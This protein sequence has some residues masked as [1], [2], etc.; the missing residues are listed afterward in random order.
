MLYDFS[1]DNA[2]KIIEEIQN[3]AG[4][5]GKWALEARKQYINLRLRQDLE[6]RKLYQRTIKNIAKQLKS[7]PNNTHLKELETFIQNEIDKLTGDFTSKMQSYIK[8]AVDAGSGYSEA[9]IIDLVK[10]A[11][12]ENAIRVSS[13]KNIYSRVNTQAVEAI[14][15]RTKK[16]LK[17]SDRIWQTGENARNTIRD[18]IQESVVTGQDAVK[19]ARMLE[20]YVQGG[21]KTL[22]AEYPNMMKRMKGRIPKD[23]SYEALRLARTETTAAFG[24]GTI[25]AARVTPSY[26]G[27]KWILSKAHPLE[28]ICDTLAEADGWGLGAGVYPPGEEP[29]YPAHPNC[30][31]VL[32]PIH[33]QPEEFVQRLKRWRVNPDSEPDIEKWYNTIYKGQSNIGSAEIQRPVF[34]KIEKHDLNYDDAEDKAI[35]EKELVM[36]PDSHRELLKREGITIQTGYDISRYDRRNKIIRVGK[37]P[38][39]GEIV[40]EI[41]HVIETIFD[42][43]H[44]RDY[45]AVLQDGIPVDEINLAHIFMS[46]EFERPVYLLEHPKI[47]KFVDKRQSIVYPLDI[48]KEGWFIEKNGVVIF[49]V[50]CLGEYFAEGYRMYLQNPQLLQKRDYKLYRFIERLM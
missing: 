3:A 41:G 40:H 26:K 47:N 45:L 1:R 36:I 48:D 11:G 37:K 50:K 39:L 10:K 9:V 6:I 5:Y 27:M 25:A 42:L 7:N 4:E 8:N 12:V 32:L 28:D 15:A 31:C 35:I 33:E 14:W 30:L 38:E 19:T 34:L 2:R 29:M 17:L 18:I 13:I 46:D 20:R 22:T 49:N 44:N 23:I 24:E 16:G 43:Y 21:A